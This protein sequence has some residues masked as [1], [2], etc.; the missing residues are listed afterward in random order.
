MVEE[1]IQ[2]DLMFDMPEK[3]WE[4]LDEYEGMLAIHDEKICNLISDSIEGQRK[5]QVILPEIK[6]V[7]NKYPEVILKGDWDIDNYNL[8]EHK[9]HLKYNKP[10]KNL[11]CYINLR[12]ADWLKGKL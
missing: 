10:I 8:V 7:F 6:R 11:V 4:A 3:Y 5:A 12:L 9:I 1:T 2:Q